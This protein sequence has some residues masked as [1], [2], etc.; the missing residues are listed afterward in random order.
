MKIE[1]SKLP[2]FPEEYDGIDAFIVGGWI[3]DFLREDVEPA[4][5]DIMVA[6]V[7]KEELLDRGFR[8]VDSANNDTFGVFFDSLGREVAM[9][10]EEAST[11]EGHKAFDVEP[12]DASLPVDE[13]IERDL[14]RRDFTVNAMAVNREGELID[15]HDGRKDLRGLTKI[16]AVDDSAFIHDPLRI[17]RAARFAA[18]LEAKIE[19][20]TLMMMK[21]MS[22]ELPSL[23]DER[24]RM[25]LEK[26]LVQ[27]DTPSHFF[28]VLDIV[29]ALEYTFPEIDALTEIPS[30]P[31]EFHK[32]GSAF[33][34]TMMVLD[35]MKDIRPDDEL[36]LLMAL[37]HDLGKGVTDEEY[38]PSH[39][40]H[41]KAGL[42]I[43]EE[44]AE[45][46]SMS[47]EKEKYMKDASRYHMRMHN[48]EKL[49]ESTI[50]ETIQDAADPARLVS[51]A[52]ADTRGR[53]P[54]GEFD[55]SLTFRRFADASQA[56]EEW[57]GQRLIDEGYSP[58]EMGGKEFGNLLRQKRVERMRELEQ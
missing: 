46:L 57:T 7:S 34:H 48:I 38:L 28:D 36:A 10:R 9:S 55:A 40:A 6:G 2:P 58:E 31:Y 47:N 42:P 32:E 54:S 35:E 50:I 33:R 19:V 53:R 12:I 51:L 3:R 21:D 13:A 29:G 15:P 18:R 17:L 1:K 4:D 26:V 44:M 39:P 24:H 56:I 22:S 5:V 14:K 25:E 49:N 37:S 11:G 41:G 23:P 30:G 20:G 27:A 16:R 52:Q 45:R 8:P 43:I